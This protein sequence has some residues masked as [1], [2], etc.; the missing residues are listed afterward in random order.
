MRICF[1]LL[2]VATITFPIKNAIAQLPMRAGG[3]DRIEGKAVDIGAGAGG[4]IWIVGTGPS[5]PDG[6]RI[7]RLYGDRFAPVSDAFGTE[8]SVAVD[9][10]AWQINNKLDIWRQKEQIPFNYRHDF[11]LGS[12]DYIIQP[13]KGG[14]LVSIKLHG[15]HED[16][17]G[18]TEY[19]SILILA[20]DSG[21]VLWTSPA[22]KLHV[23]GHFDKLKTEENE[24]TNYNI[25]TETLSR[26]RQ[27]VI[28]CDRNR[29]TDTNINEILKVL[30]DTVLVIR[31]MDGDQQ[32]IGEL[33]GKH[34]LP[35]INK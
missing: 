26:V 15:I 27:G 4:V 14:S 11:A 34:V 9:G 20:D 24:Q 17:S 18:K 13:G 35:A 30:R 23:K 21:Q 19:R 3:S 1:H 29:T 8:I 33:I 5:G 31:A 10:T 25:S 2:F 16:I 32:A 22:A 6:N 12:V 7:Y 28:I